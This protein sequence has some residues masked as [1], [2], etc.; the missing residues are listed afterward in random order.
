MITHDHRHGI[1]QKPATLSQF[2][3]VVPSFWSRNV[4]GIW[5]VERSTPMRGD[6][7]VFAA[8]LP[9]GLVDA[10]HLSPG[11]H[12]AGRARR[13]CPPPESSGVLTKRPSS[14]R[15]EGSFARDVPASAPQGR[16]R[17]GQSR[18]QTTQYQYLLKSTVRRR[19]P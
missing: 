12:D 15:P 3:K 7:R 1:Q 14:A 10:R 9:G 8:G 11:P 4:I 18:L 13:N 2:A 16:T 19:R 6:L 17:V 5:R